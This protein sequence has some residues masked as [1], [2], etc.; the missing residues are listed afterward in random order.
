M[1][2]YLSLFQSPTGNVELNR[3]RV[4]RCCR[5]TDSGI[6]LK[7]A[8][9]CRVVVVGVTK[10]FI[11]RV[12]QIHG[13]LAGSHEQSAVHLDLLAVVRRMLIRH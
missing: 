7:P 11:N 6:I 5:E 8:L 1:I 10:C 2:R 9:A 3:D 4:G 13:S 12:Q